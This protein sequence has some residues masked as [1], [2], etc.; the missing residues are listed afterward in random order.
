MNETEQS[1]EIT[2]KKIHPIAWRA[3]VWL[4]DYCGLSVF[5]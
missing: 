4:L 1:I 3:I 2:S 5:V